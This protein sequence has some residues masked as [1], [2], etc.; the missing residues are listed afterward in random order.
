MVVDA[1]LENV[2][3]CI[4]RGEEHL[5]LFEEA[6]HHVYT[7]CNA[8]NRN[9]KIHNVRKRILSAA[10]RAFARW[11]TPFT[12]TNLTRCAQLLDDVCLSMNNAVK[13]SGLEKM[14]SAV[15]ARWPAIQRQRAALGLAYICK[16]SNIVPLPLEIREMILARATSD[17]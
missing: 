9:N 11:M 6:Y 14:Q 12:A 15:E 8:K 3:K 1:Y 10:T 16:A 4:A 17:S 7:L 5:V 2:L 13:A